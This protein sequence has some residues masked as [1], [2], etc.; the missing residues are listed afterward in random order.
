MS[1]GSISN[2]GIIPRQNNPVIRSD[3]AVVG[4]LPTVGKQAM[5]MKTPGTSI[6]PARNV[7][8]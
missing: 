8:R 3:H 6:T 7:F 2:T 4:R 5:Q 1:P